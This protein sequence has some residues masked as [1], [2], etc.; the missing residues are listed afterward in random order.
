MNLVDI[1]KQ[2]ES[3]SVDLGVARYRKGRGARGRQQR[4]WTPL[5]S[6]TT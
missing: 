6:F 1:Q 3:E 2:L 5:F 4:P